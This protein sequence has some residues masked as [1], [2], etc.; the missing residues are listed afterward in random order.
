MGVGWGRDF[1]LVCALNIV[2]EH[3]KQT[4]IREG[5]VV[6]LAFWGT[7][8][9]NLPKVITQGLELF[10]HIMEG[11]VAISPFIRWLCKCVQNIE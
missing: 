7:T 6:K 11:P 5:S 9:T 2:I 10:G 1:T 8:Y 4:V 3:F